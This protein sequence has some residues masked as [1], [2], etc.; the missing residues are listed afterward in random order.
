MDQT[1]NHLE[2]EVKVKVPDHAAIRQRLE[3]VGAKLTAERVY[4]RNVRYEDAENNL[5][6]S[7]RVLRLRQATRARLTYK[8]PTKQTFEGVQTRVELEVTVSDFEMMDT[9]LGKLGF[10]PAWT[11]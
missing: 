6:H 2:I 4:E 10:F 8:E 1:A 9:I 11:Y 7:H 3:E 5:T